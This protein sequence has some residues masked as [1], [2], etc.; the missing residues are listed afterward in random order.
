MVQWSL[1]KF[2]TLWFTFLP[3]LLQLLSTRLLSLYGIYFN[4]SK[5]SVPKRSYR[6]KGGKTTVKFIHITYAKNIQFFT[7]CTDIL[8]TLIIN[9]KWIS[10][11]RKNE[12]HKNVWLT[13]IKKKHIKIQLHILEEPKEYLWSSILND[14]MIRPTSCYT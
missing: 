10:F 8:N 6:F 7:L 5:G 4:A 2:I 1:F 11:V 13:M 3:L 14:R 9:Y 12:M